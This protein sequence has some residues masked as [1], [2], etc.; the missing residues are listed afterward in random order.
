MS[1]QNPCNHD[2]WVK[3]PIHPCKRQFKNIPKNEWDKDFEDLLNS[4]Q[5]HTQCS[6]GYCS[7]RK[8]QEDEV[9][10]R[11]NFPKENCEQT[12]LEY[13]NLKSKDGEEHYKVK[14]VTKRNDNCLNNHQR[15]QLQDGE[16]I[17]LFK[18]SLTTILAWSTWENKAEKISSVARD[19]FTSVLCEPSNQTDGKRALRKLMMRAVG[20]RDMSIQEVIIII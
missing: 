16:Q 7:H 3:P 15:I 1:T 5:R 18:L 19:A 17:V 4:V 6:T 2:D 20:K 9:S 13:E 11:F 8:G 14:V 10:C 12:H